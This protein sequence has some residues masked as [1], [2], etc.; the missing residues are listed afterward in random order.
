MLSKNII[1]FLQNLKENNNRQWFNEHKTEF[2][3]IWKNFQE[4][5]QVM[6]NEIATI[7][8]SIKSVQVKDCLFRIYRDVRFAK[9]KSPY[10]TNLGAYVVNGGRHSILAGYY[11]HIEPDNCMFAGGIYMPKPEVLRKIWNAI[12]NNPNDLKEILNNKEYKKHYG[13][14]SDEQYKSVPR[15]FPKDFPDAE[16]LKFK[17]YTV[18]KIVPNDFYLKDN[19]IKE[20]KELTRVMYPFNSYFNE[21]LEE[22]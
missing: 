18:G 9:D 1:E 22:K 2:D 15:G 6:I 4:F 5:V 20:V 7:D 12:Y 19:V 3:Q 17:S 16:L 10:K 11:I 14:L 13:G 8:S 21:I